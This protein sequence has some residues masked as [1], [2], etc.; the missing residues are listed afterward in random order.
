MR[1]VA[2]VEVSLKPGLLDPQGKAI[3]GSL[4]A[5]GWSNVS[6]VRV[7][8]YVRLV[9]DATDL[10]AATTQVGDMSRRLLSNPVIED[11]VIREVLEDA[12]GNDRA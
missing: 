8:K 11:A 12:V 7:G 4:P 10:E 2:H 1:Y 5:L 9:V 3:E 6:D